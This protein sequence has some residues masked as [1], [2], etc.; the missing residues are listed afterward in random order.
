M[1]NYQTQFSCVFPVGEANIA[2]ALALFEQMQDE[3]EADD[4]TIGFTVERNG[5]DG[6]D[7]WLYDDD[8]AGD[9]EHVISFAL[10]CAERF[11]LRGTWGFHWSLSCD[12]PKLNCFGGGAQV[13]D[14]GRRE[15]LAWL[16]CEHWVAMRTDADGPCREPAEKILASVADTEEWTEAKRLGVLLGFIDRLITTDPAIAGQ[17]RSHL[18]DMPA[19]GDNMTCGECGKPPFIADG[20]TSHHAGDGLDGID[21]GRDR[22]HT[23][24]AE[25]AVPSSSGADH[26]GVAEARTEA[27]A[28]TRVG[29]WYATGPA[30]RPFVP[31]DPAWAVHRV[32]SD[33]ATALGCVTVE[34]RAGQRF[35][36]AISLVDAI[37]APVGE[38]YTLLDCPAEHGEQRS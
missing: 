17:F 19:T 29:R 1:A 35:P 6:G 38:R 33:D 32:V 3:L 11:E 26:P 12:R 15:S 4:V 18:A 30:D 37:V 36:V 23:A 10:R 16:D 5:E 21:H 25:P 34:N 8:G 7:L 9:V 24:T 14:L 31:D 2:A 28:P 20:D 22:G 13:L 27:T